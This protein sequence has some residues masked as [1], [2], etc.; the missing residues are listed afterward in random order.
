MQI[1]MTEFPDPLQLVSFQQLSRVSVVAAVAPHFWF[2]NAA[3]HV[4]SHAGHA[5][6]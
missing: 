2:Q 1:F 5:Y 6:E 4:P 3:L